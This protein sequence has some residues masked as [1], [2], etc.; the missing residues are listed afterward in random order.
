MGP[1]HPVAFARP[2][3]IPC[4]KI[5]LETSIS[6]KFS[7]LDAL[8][9]VIS[10]PSKCQLRSLELSPNSRSLGWAPPRQDGAL[11][12]QSANPRSVQT[13]A[14]RSCRLL[15]PAYPVVPLPMPVMCHRTQAYS[16]F[17]FQAN[18]T[19]QLT[20]LVLLNQS[21]TLCATYGVPL[22]RRRSFTQ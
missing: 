10:L 16:G 19:S 11:R 7:P 13:R 5:E 18:Q 17:K 9:Q 8:T 3:L 20:I 15:S 2:M 1:I 22:P 4:L 6:W 14:L 21:L 12:L